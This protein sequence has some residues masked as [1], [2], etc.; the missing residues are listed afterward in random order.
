[1]TVEKYVVSKETLKR[2]VQLIA[3]MR[4]AKPGIRSIPLFGL[5]VNAAPEFSI[6]HTYY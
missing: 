5:S 6:S 1:M 3:T 4:Q 2:L